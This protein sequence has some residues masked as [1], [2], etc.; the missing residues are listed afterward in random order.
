MVLLT[1]GS[2]YTYSGQSLYTFSG[3]ATDATASVDLVDDAIQEQNENFFGNLSFVASPRP[4]N[5]V[6]N[7][8]LAEAT[9]MDNDSMLN[10]IAYISVV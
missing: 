10:N 8:S 6:L 1:L 9:I 4:A 3:I 7:P 5:V 2:D